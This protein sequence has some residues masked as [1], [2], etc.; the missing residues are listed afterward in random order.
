VA[1]SPSTSPPAEGSAPDRAARRRAN[2]TAAEILQAIRRWNDRYGEPPTMADWDP[3]RA[4][5]VG[6]EWRIARYDEGD[7]PSM[8]TVRN[9][10]GRLST[11]VAHAGLVPRRQG[12]QRPQPELAIDR[13]TRVHLA[14]LRILREGQATPLVLAAAVREVSKAQ[15]SNRPDDLRVALIDL[16]AAALSWSTAIDEQITTDPEQRKAP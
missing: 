7:W 2:M 8:K 10:F 15:V 9:H 13:D 12:Q 5:T 14:H 6:Q 3:Y 11:A 16:A 1:G 4:R